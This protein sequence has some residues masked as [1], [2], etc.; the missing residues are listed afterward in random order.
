MR[1]RVDYSDR[2]NRVTSYIYDHLDDEIDLERVRFELNHDRAPSFCFDAFSSNAFSSEVESGSREENAF[3]YHLGANS[4][5]K[6]VPTFAKFAPLNRYPLR[7]K[8][9]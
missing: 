6:P 7:L 2:L 1:G 9:L 8:T 5:A 3:V 4:N